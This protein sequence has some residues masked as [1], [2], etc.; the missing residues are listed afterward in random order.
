MVTMRSCDTNTCTPSS[1]LFLTNVAMVLGYTGLATEVPTLSKEP[2]WSGVP[3]S[4]MYSLLRQ[5]IV[6]ESRV[7]Q[8]NVTTSPGQRRSKPPTELAR[9]W[10]RVVWG[11]CTAATVR[12]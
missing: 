3:P 6:R 11:K 7:S 4:S 8:V 5:V 12:R 9:D 2:N 1:L 10:E